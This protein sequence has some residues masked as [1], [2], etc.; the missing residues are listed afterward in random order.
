[1]YL[2]SFRQLINSNLPNTQPLGLFSYRE[3][4]R[5]LNFSES[6]AKHNSLN[7]TA[8]LTSM[9]VNIKLIRLNEIK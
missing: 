9:V 7:S 6:L 1:M 5:N 4:L 2:K 3:T 8:H